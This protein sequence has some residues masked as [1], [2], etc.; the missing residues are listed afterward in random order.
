MILAL[1]T[2]LTAGFAVGHASGT[3]YIIPGGLLAGWIVGM[4]EMNAREKG[5]GR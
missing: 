5:S 4:L 2:A 3:M 1:V